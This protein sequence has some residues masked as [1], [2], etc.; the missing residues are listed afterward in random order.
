MQP[1]LILFFSSLL[2]SRGSL[3]EKHWNA[4]F[5]ILK[6]TI[7]KAKE[8]AN[9]SIHHSILKT[10]GLKPFQV[11]TKKDFQIFFRKS[12][13]NATSLGVSW[14]DDGNHMEHA[15]NKTNNHYNRKK[16]QHRAVYRKKT[17]DDVIQTN[18]EWM[19]LLHSFRSCRSQIEE[20]HLCGSTADNKK[21]NCLWSRTERTVKSSSWKGFNSYLWLG[22]LVT[23]Y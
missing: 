11:S 15:K 10:C 9:Q 3:S 12:F 6:P 16:L 4:N 20:N 21:D 8:G 22:W 17:S 19:I 1:F 23:L 5:F 7:C 13:T 14:I 2:H 18:K